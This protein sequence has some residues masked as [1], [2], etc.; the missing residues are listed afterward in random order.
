MNSWGGLAKR[1]PSIAKSVAQYATARPKRALTPVF[2]GVWTRMNAF[3]AIVPYFCPSMIIACVM[4]AQHAHHNP[5][6][7]RKVFVAGAVQRLR[8]DNPMV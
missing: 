7:V 4:A 6:T 2:D 1:N 8:R 3:V 5:W